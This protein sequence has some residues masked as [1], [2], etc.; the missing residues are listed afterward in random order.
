MWQNVGKPYTDKTFFDWWGFRK[1][2]PG[3]IFVSIFL[4]VLSPTWIQG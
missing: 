4:P 3:F 1:L 2:Q